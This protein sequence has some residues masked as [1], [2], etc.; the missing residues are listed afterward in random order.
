MLN[1]VFYWSVSLI[2]ENSV[3]YMRYCA[4]FDYLI[5][6][7]DLRIYCGKTEGKFRLTDG[8]I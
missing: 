1:L 5:N 4:I 6:Y 3:V 8:Y 2:I 7:R